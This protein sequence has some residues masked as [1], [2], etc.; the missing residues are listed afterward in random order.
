MKNN[1]INMSDI[2][3]K[4]RRVLVIDL[5]DALDLLIGE[6]DWTE[7]PVLGRR[8]ARCLAWETP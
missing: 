6:R 3:E 8:C 1:S 7:V 5:E 2:D 4:D